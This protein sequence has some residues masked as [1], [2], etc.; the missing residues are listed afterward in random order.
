MIYLYLEALTCR[1]A[2]VRAHAF[3][4]TLPGVPFREEQGPSMR[5]RT[6]EPWMRM[7]GFGAQNLRPALRFALF[8]LQDSAIARTLKS[9]SLPLQALPR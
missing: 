2:A 7:L 9:L 3:P 4:M 6:R 8:H 1:I 5:A